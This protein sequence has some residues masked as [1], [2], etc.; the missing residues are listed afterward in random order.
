MGRGLKRSTRFS[1]LDLNLFS[2]LEGNKPGIPLSFF[3]LVFEKLKFLRKHSQDHHYHNIFCSR[4][5]R[6]DPIQAEEGGQNEKQRQEE[7]ENL[8]Q[9]NEKCCSDP[10]Y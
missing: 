5:Y 3:R 9:I 7:H 8:S 2:M 1:S 4:R 6:S 10:V